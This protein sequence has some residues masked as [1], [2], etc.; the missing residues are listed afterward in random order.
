MIGLQLLKASQFSNNIHQSFV[1]VCNWTLTLFSL[2]EINEI[3][4]LDCGDYVWKWGSKAKERNSFT[5][6]L[7]CSLW[8]TEEFQNLRNCAF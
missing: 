4:G 7:L 3:L 1:D 6:Y 8:L 5:A 2:A